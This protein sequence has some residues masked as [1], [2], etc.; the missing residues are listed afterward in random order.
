MNI[1][2]N[3]LNKQEKRQDKSIEETALIASTGQPFP[4]SDLS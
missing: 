3:V 4:D 2:K 1:Q